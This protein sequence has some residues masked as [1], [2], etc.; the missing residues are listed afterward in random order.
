MTVETEGVLDE[1]KRIKNLQPRELD[2]FREAHH[3]GD[4]IRLIFSD[5]T[6]GQHEK[7]FRL[8]HV[9]RDQLAVARG[10]DKEQ[11]KAFLKYKHGSGAI[12]W[13]PFFKP[14]LGQRG[15]FLEVNG[16]IYWLKS[17]TVYTTDELGVLVE[18]TVKELNE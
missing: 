16:T 1:H 14:P 17:T 12:P 13:A 10:E 11:M 8:F 6:E 2:S 4:V 7:L 18:G 5:E 15:A 9:Y 3:P